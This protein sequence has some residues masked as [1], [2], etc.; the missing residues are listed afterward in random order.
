[1]NGYETFQKIKELKINTP[2]IA[3]TAFAQAED[4]IK[5]IEAGFSDYITKPVSRNVLL[6]KIDYFFQKK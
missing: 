5:C 1:M 4:A 6:N 3:Q 2:V